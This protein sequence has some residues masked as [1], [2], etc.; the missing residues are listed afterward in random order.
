MP[1]PVPCALCGSERESEDHL[2][3]DCQTLKVALGWL[4]TVIESDNLKRAI[5]CHDFTRGDDPAKDA[6]KSE[7]LLIYRWSIWKARKRA[8]Y[9]GVTYTQNSLLQSFKDRVRRHAQSLKPD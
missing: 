9:D 6:V 3:M 5:F 7:I 4:Q 1:R 2:F 8:I